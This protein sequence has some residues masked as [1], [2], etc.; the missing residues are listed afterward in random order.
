MKVVFPEKVMRGGP[1]K[2]RKKQK[3]GRREEPAD[4]LRT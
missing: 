3:A 1:K 4:S 2:G